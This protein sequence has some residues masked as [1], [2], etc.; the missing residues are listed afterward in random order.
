LDK[1]EGKSARDGMPSIIVSIR[2]LAER[3]KG[4]T[5]SIFDEGH[6]AAGTPGVTRLD[7]HRSFACRWINPKERGD[8]PDM[9][10]ETKCKPNVNNCESRVIKE[11]IGGELQVAITKSHRAWG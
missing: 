10:K 7:L 2:S 5:R 8:S 4:G 9:A 3:Q 1:K 6:N 11:P